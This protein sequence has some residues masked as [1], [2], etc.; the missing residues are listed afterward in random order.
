VSDSRGEAVF[1]DLVP[2][3]YT[4]RF[5]EASL[6]RFFEPTTADVVADVQPG[7]ITRVQLGA[8]EREK[9]TLQTLSTGELSL[10]VSIDPLPAPVGAE[11]LIS[12]TVQGQPLSVSAS[13]AEQSVEL[14]LRP[15]GTF[16]ARLSVPE[17]AAG[18]LMITVRAEN[19]EAVREQ[20][21][22]LIIG[23]GPLAKAGVTPTIARPGETL[24]FEALLLKL[25]DSLWLLLGGER[26]EL[27]ETD[28]PYRFLGTLVAPQ[29][30]GLHAA[31]LFGDGV[32]LA[33]ARFRVR[34]Q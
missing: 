2:G 33:E 34:Y 16:A 15:D 4:L 30:G 27:Q 14:G 22:P 18:M 9:E 20:R 24:N 26:F 31:E 28:D 17:D 32:K 1:Q 29:E 6:P 25:P 3:N 8:A 12:A 19:E 10:A 7:P 13:L 5:D 11:V 21:L 23:S